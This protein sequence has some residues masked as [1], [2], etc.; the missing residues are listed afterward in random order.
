[1]YAN[2]IATGCRKQRVWKHTHADHATYAAFWQ[3][4]LA[5]WN[6]GFISRVGSGVVGVLRRQR[7]RRTETRGILASQ[8]TV[9]YNRVTR[10]GGI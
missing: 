10:Q 3:W 2:Y 5:Q 4:W 8:H 7:T 6:V 9:L 1:L